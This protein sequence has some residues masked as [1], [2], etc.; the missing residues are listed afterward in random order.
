M[1]TQDKGFLDPIIKVRYADSSGPWGY[2]WTENTCGR[3]NLAYRVARE[4]FGIATREAL[5]ALIIDMSIRRDLEHRGL[6]VLRADM[7]PDW[8]INQ[9]VEPD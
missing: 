6:D 3:N 1:P 5:G 4:L 9:A 7:I 8:V 2:A